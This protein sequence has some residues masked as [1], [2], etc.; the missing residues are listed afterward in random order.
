MRRRVAK[1]I[2]TRVINDAGEREY[3]SA[4]GTHPRL[5]RYG[6]RRDRQRGRLLSVPRHLGVEMF[7]RLGRSEKWW[8]HFVDFQTSSWAEPPIQPWR[9]AYYIGTAPRRVPNEVL[10]IVTFDAI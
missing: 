4:P 10:T 2:I 7:G 3:R 6:M 5:V 9:G 1:K 8:D